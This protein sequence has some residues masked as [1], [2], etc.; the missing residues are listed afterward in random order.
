MNCAGLLNETYKLFARLLTLREYFE[1]II[2]AKILHV[3][4]LIGPK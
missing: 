2:Y 4:K 1:G 3:I